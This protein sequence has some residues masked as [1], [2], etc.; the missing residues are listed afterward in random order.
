MNKCPRCN[1]P[2]N[3]L[4]ECKYCGYDFT[5]NKKK[6]TK[7]IRRK[8]KDI[9]SGFKEIQIVSRNKKSKVHSVNNAGK[10]FKKTDEG[11]TRSGIDRRKQ[12]YTTYY[13]EKRSGM[14]RRKR[15]DRRGLIARN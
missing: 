2:Q 12:K 4:N 14:D 10:A 8:L 13:P 9:V 15:F 5:K 7:I 1:L 6:H 3:R 11:G